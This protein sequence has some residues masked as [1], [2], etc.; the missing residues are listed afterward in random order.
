MDTNVDLPM[1]MARRVSS[2]PISAAV[3]FYTLGFAMLALAAFMVFFLAE[4]EHIVKH[5]RGTNVTSAMICGVAALSYFFMARL[6]DP[7]QPFPIAMRYID[8]S[9]T[10]PLLLVKFAEVT[11]PRGAAWLTRLI[12]ADIFMIF[13]GYIGELYG[14]TVNGTWQPNSG[15]SNAVGM[16]FLWGAISTI[17]YLYILWSLQTQGRALADKAPGHIRSGYSNMLKYVW[18][19]WGV[20]PVVYVLEGL[21]GQGMSIN[22][23]WFL[24]ASN[25]ADVLNKALFGV[26][27]YLAVRAY[28][29]DSLY[30]ND[31]HPTGSGSE[32]KVR[33]NATYAQVPG[34]IALHDI[35]EVVVRTGKEGVDE[36]I[37]TTPTEPAGA[38]Q[39]GTR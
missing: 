8:W 15:V 10:T 4:R 21:S 19:G 24:A 36:H 35:S 26:T 32:D 18:I 2:L 23:D 17:G 20:Y 6:Y 14:A 39:N 22:L 7:S 5:Y 28:S 31:R 33:E 27:V 29:G 13:T 30:D 9:I 1:E 37:D 12:I 11:K 38:N 25:V 34:R 16:H 3:V